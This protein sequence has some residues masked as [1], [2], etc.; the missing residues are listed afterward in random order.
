MLLTIITPYYN[1]LEYTKRLSD[2]LKPQLN[3]KVEWIIIDDGC[4][5]KELDDLGA[6]VIHLD[7]NTGNASI[8]RNIGLDK[9]KG[10]Y[11]S[12]V[13]S[14][15]LVS[16]VYV[17]KIIQ[18]IESSDFDYCYI[19]WKTKDYVYLIDEEPLT[20]NTGVWN[21]I[22]NKDMIGKTRFDPKCNLGEDKDFNSKV[23]KGKRENIKEILYYY[24]WKRPGS[25]STCYREG[26]IKF[27]REE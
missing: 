5:E 2:M 3:D 9:A 23:K 22:Y 15:D 26:K 24:N 19:G 10:K 27:T 18:K 13:D 1:T 16:P 14:D 12:F 4:N 6:R 8:P 11:I 7:K 21:C 20:W 25:I 17:K